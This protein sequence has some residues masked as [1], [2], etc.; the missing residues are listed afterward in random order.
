[1]PEKTL[2]T[3]L[4]YAARDVMSRSMFAA[5]RQYGGGAVLDIG[6]WDFYRTA[7]RKGISFERWTVLERD[8]NNV[9]PGDDPRVDV[10]HGDGCRMIFPDNRFDTVLGIQVAEH[11]FEPIRLLSEAVRVLRPGGHGIFLVPQTG[12]LHMAPHH[13][14]NFTR[15][16]ILEATRRAGLELVELTPLGGGW[17]TAASR[18][19]YYA[20]QISG[21]RGMTYPG[22]RRSVWFYVLS[23]LMLL[24]IAVNIP[25][26]LALSLGD[27]EEEA[28]NHLFVF[29]KP[30]A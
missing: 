9:L 28:N 30:A 3:R 7:I 6:G 26:C 16:W 24:Y 12:N 17:T 2:L 20:L 19:I 4:G 27:F 15:F 1:M 14:Q 13:Y 18:L 22:A 21:M 8:P 29:R 25:L 5:M 23:P 11:V 10:V